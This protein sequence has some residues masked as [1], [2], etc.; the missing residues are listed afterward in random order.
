[1]AQ[2]VDHDVTSGVVT[3]TWETIKGGI[4]ALAL[5]P[6]LGA[7]AAGTAAAV[8]TALFISTGIG[9]I[10]A[11]GAIGVIAGG[12]LG[13]AA[14]T[15]MAPWLAGIGGGIGLLKGASRIRSESRAYDNLEAGRNAETMVTH[16]QYAAQQGYMAGVQAGQQSVVDQLQQVRYAA[17]A[18]KMGPA[19]EK[20]HV[21]V[22]EQRRAA[23][24]A[25]TQTRVV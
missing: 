10:V 25:T 21:A 17:I 12:L 14:S 15:A 2:P 8:V 4:G 7:A 11:G 20:S 18:D 13:T 19:P 23:A 24:A 3:T 5:P 16:M 6:V 22:E 1:M 9:A